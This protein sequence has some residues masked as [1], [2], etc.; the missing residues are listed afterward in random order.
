MQ[1]WWIELTPL[2][3]A[4]CGVAVFFSLLFLWQIL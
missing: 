1:A 2:N 3:Q 4:L